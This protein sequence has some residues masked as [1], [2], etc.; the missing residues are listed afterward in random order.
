MLALLFSSRFW[1]FR[2]STWCSCVW[3]YRWSAF[4][5]LYALLG[6]L[7]CFWIPYHSWFHCGVCLCV[8]QEKSSWNQFLHKK[9]KRSSK[10]THTSDCVL[11]TNYSLNFQKHLST[12][13]S[14]AFLNPPEMCAPKSLPHSLVFPCRTGPGAEQE[15]LKCLTIYFLSGQLELQRWDN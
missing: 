2:V 4:P 12:L 5:H 3:C 13:W 8:R 14:N 15:S 11:F 7:L 10:N 9:L 6:V 1:N